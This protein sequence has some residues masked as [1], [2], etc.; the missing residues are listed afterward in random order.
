[1]KSRTTA[2]FRKSFAALPKQVQEQT[3]EA[4][5]QFKENPSYPSLRFKKVHSELPIYSARIS[6]NYRAVGQL[7]GDTVIWFWVG[8]H[9][10]YDRLLSQL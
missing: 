2:E 4:Y 8:S 1:M 5:R 3:R 6:N 9:A 7:D 10:D